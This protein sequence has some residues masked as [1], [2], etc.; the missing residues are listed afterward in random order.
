[1]TNDI[2]ASEY[3]GARF[4]DERLSKRLVKLAGRV[5]NDPSASFPNSLTEAELEGAYRFF[6]NP[7]VGPG[8][9]LQPHVARTV[10]RVSDEG[11]AL[12]LHDTTTLSFRNEGQ[13]QGF[14]TMT[15][16]SQ[17]LW[18][19][20]TLVVKADQTRCPL[21]VLAL[22]TEASIRHERWLENVDCANEMVGGPAQLVH[23]MD[24]EADDYALFAHML[25]KQARF[26]V[27]LQHD[28]QVESSAGKG[29]RITEALSS[30][31]LVAEREVSLSARGTNGGSKTRRVHP[32]RHARL[33]HLSIAATPVTVRCP[34]AKKGLP[35]SLDL[36]AVRVWEGSPPVNQPSVEW[37]LLTSEPIN[38]AEDLLR[39]VDWYRAR[40]TIEEFFK[41]LKTGCSI[42]KRQLESFHSF[43]N[44]VAFFT[45]IA[46]QLLLLRHRAHHE[47]DADGTSSLPDGMLDV[48]RHIARKPLP[49]APSAKDVLFAVAA[50]GGHLK[51]NGDPGWQ[52]LGRGYD[53]LRDAAEIWSIAV[54][55]LR[56]DQS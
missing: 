54:K 4:K 11:V 21:G 40:W 44:A 1:V 13:R 55:V 46:W 49:D 34:R 51:R 27:R 25:A 39:V 28:R 26:V 56:S 37:L 19:H 3:A 2:V 30:A 42:E 53:K 22:T 29:L 24:R 32:P 9:V 33:A 20:A 12:A 47:T 31:V 18:T 35:K 14:G 17:Q 16:A 10:A 23:V 50:L 41:A 6:G 7:K 48:L 36:H 8:H 43:S 38:S 52:T 5:A 15:G 45:P